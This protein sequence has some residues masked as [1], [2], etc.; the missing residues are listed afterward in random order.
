MSQEI[1]SVA[2]VP[3]VMRFER[4]QTILESEPALRER[5]GPKDQ[6][7]YKRNQERHFFSKGVVA[8]TCA[9]AQKRIDAHSANRNIVLSVASS[10]LGIGSDKA[11]VLKITQPVRQPVKQPVKV[12]EAKKPEVKALPAPV[13]ATVPK[14]APP[15][16]KAPKAAP[17]PKAPKATVPKPE[18]PAPVPAPAP[19]QVQPPAPAAPA[20]QPAA[21]E[22][23][24]VEEVEPLQQ[25]PG[26]YIYTTI[27]AL[28]APAFQ[29]MELGDNTP[30]A[31]QRKGKLGSLL[32]DVYKLKDVAVPLPP[33]MLPPS[34]KDGQSA[35]S[36]SKG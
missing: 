20:T 11:P 14:P 22:P 35:S 15:K 8:V 3:S 26:Y 29:L 13:P 7:V 2:V 27:Y 25:V 31:E 5:L 17:K 30:G 16:P 12:K 32:E 4:V 6:A 34:L 21:V 33:N 1:N 36:N 28:L 19:V 24:P 10:V 23:A 18:P 9:L